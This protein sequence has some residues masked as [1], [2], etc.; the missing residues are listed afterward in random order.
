MGDYT[1]AERMKRRREK[2]RAAGK[3]TVCGKR[4]AAKGLT[5]CKICN[6]EAYERVKAS[7]A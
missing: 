5:V 3:C 2:L 1:A 4:K 6:A 7:R